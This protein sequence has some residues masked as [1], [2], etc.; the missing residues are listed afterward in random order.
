MKKQDCERDTYGDDVTSQGS[1]RPPLYTCP[2][3]VQA[4][5]G[6][7]RHAPLS[8]MTVRTCLKCRQ[9]GHLHQQSKTFAA[10]LLASKHTEPPQ[11][12]PCAWG[13]H[14]SRPL[15]APP[16]NRPSSTQER[17]QSQDGQCRT[18]DLELT[19]APRLSVVKA[20]LGALTQ[21]N[22]TEENPF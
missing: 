18:S 11:L 9:T 7:Q 5:G 10:K 8:P 14:C 19:A 3:C 21:F 17:T 13:H 15:E 22:G 2:G 4:A 20:Q 1:C 16:L 6:R 12:V